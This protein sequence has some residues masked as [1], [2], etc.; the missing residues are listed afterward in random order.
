[1]GLRLLQVALGNGLQ[2]SAQICL[3]GFVSE[4]NGVKFGE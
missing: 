3:G 4:V 2:N 1:V